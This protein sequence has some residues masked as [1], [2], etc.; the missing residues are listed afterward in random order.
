MLKTSESVRCFLNG[1]LSSSSHM[2]FGENLRCWLWL[3]NIYLHRWSL[4]SVRA[5][6]D[7]KTLRNCDDHNKCYLFWTRE[8][9]CWQYCFL[10][11]AVHFSTGSSKPR[12][13]FLRECCGTQSFQ[14]PVFMLYS[15]VQNHFMEISEV[16]V[17]TRCKGYAAEIAVHFHFTKYLQAYLPG[18]GY[19]TPNSTVKQER[20]PFTIP[21]TLLP[22]PEIRAVAV[23]GWA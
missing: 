20:C 3:I 5:Y 9:R 19:K 23:L 13:C 18:C 2:T 1:S 15:W 6:C 22:R 21:S 4:T 10:S 16:L 8:G 12:A 7:R 17:H 14:N 11:L